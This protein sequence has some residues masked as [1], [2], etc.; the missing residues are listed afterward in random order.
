[1][2]NK[3]DGRV[4]LVTGGKGTIGKSIVER[5][6]EEGADVYIADLPERDVRRPDSIANLVYDIGYIDILINAAGIQTPIGP[7]NTASTSQWI[8]T[9]NTNLIGTMVCTQL[10]LPNM[11]K[12]RK[13]KIVNFGGGGAIT[14]R[15]NFSAYASSKAGVI[16][17][18]ETIAEEVKQYNIDINAVHPGSVDTPM[19]QDVLDAGLKAGKSELK[20]AK[21][22]RDGK[23]I[24]PEDVASFILFLS[25]KDSDGITGRTIYNI[26]DGWKNLKAKD[27]E[28]NSLYTLRR[29]DGRR[30]IERS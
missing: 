23:S 1:M 26:W 8:N 20:N 14:P 3:L 17:F 27:F 7:L 19:I 2:S 12:R 22:V 5:F 13:G 15:P 21:G 9:I 24:S 29:I 6:R 28:S 18:T 11:I 4:A 16:R 10:V 25:C 30:Y